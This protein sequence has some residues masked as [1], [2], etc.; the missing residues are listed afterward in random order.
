MTQ[1]SRYPYTYADDYIRGVAG[2]GPGGTKIGR[3]DAGNIIEAICNAAG[4]DYYTVCCALADCELAKTEEDIE[5]Q[6]LEALRSL[7][8]T[9]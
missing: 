2:C 6:A 9:V 3:S 5:Q 8:L 4:Q 7:N 1:D